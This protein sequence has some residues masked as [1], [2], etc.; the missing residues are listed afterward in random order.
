MWCECDEGEC[1]LKREKNCC[2]GNH[3]Q[4]FPY[5][6][7]GKLRVCNVFQTILQ[8]WKSKNR[9]NSIKVPLGTPIFECNKKCKCGPTCSNRWFFSF[10]VWAI[11]LES[12]NNIFFLHMLRVVQRGRRIKLCI[13]RTSNGCGWGV[14]TLE[15]IKKGS[16]VV[17]YVGEV[18][19]SEEAERR[20]KTYGQFFLN[21]IFQNV[22]SYYL[23]TSSDTNGIT[24]LFDVDFH[25]SE[26][27]YTIDAAFYGNVA[28]FINHSCN[29]NLV[30][31]ALEP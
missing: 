17:E 14:K 12:I 21:Q 16:F 1:E 15:P 30:G 22:S 24:Y 31:T 20:G 18:I 23:F 28:H 8:T 27:L 29:P 9:F 25:D 10:G 2:P 5:T 26:N 13:F 6:K 4:N 11:F 19:L 3:N 7:F